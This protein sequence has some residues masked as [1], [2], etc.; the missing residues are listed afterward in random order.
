M[1][2]N[3]LVGFVSSR[4]KGPRNALR[5]RICTS[6]G[7]IANS[8]D[9]L[10]R[11]LPLFRPA[12]TLGGA[13]SKARTEPSARKL[14]KTNLLNPVDS[15]ADGKGMATSVHPHLWPNLAVVNERAYGS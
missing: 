12:H 10:G 1:K 9:I 15:L 3:A 11:K 5:I 2:L 13:P 8:K 6:T 4:R 14:L 7:L